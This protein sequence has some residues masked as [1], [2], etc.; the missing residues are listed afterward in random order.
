MKIK[1]FFF[2]FFKPKKKYQLSNKK[3]LRS[4]NVRITGTVPV[5][6]LVFFCSFESNK[7]EERIS[8]G[9]RFR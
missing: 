2:V 5:V 1:S 8:G 6:V 9:K 4:K 7:V 3:K